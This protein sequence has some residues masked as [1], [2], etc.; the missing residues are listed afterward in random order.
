MDITLRKTAISGWLLADIS[1]IASFFLLDILPWLVYWL[2]LCVI[3]AVVSSWRL[4]FRPDTPAVLILLSLLC[5][6]YSFARLHQSATSNT[7]SLNWQRRGYALAFLLAIVTFTGSTTVQHKILNPAL[8]PLDQVAN[9]VLKR[10]MLLTSS[11]FAT[12]RLI[13]RGIA[14]ISEAQVSIG[15]ASVKPG[16]L[17]KPL[18]DMAVR[19]SDLMV[20]A[21]TSVGIQL[22][23]LEFGKV[24]ALPLFG[25]GAVLCMLAAIAG[26]T[27]IRKAMLR[28]CTVFLM[29]LLVIRI[30]IPLAAYGTDQLTHW[31]LE[32]QRI[33]AEAELTQ[34]TA[35]LQQL[36]NQ[37]E[38]DSSG[39]ISWLKQ[40]ASK[41]SDMASAV[42]HF[43]DNMVEKLVQLI[44][45]YLLQ[46]IIFPLLSLFILWKLGRWSISQRLPGQHTVT[47]ASM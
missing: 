16:Q 20:L 35:Q 33:A 2:L 19:Y 47:A 39:I 43:S 37:P 45:I 4:L 30:G 5:P 13:D 40:T 1:Y 24:A 44:V 10:S 31:V 27:A 12:A 21:M 34:A 38:E 14:F 28:L 17:M 26:P 41:A 9:S 25:S 6:W 36:E 8:A 32:P 29:L 42:K 23:L 18:Q 3:L 46:C 22:F 7:L 11:S 15:V